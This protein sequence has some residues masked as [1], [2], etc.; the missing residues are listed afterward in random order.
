MV[1]LLD[2]TR[3]GGIFTR[4][5]NILAAVARSVKRQIQRQPPHFVIAKR[6]A[7]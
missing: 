6:R 2:F 1:F 3:H 5:N 4:N 7:D